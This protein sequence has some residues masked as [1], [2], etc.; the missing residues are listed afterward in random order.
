MPNVPI[1]T[2]PALAPT[3]GQESYVSN[4]LV[5]IIYGVPT[6]K[7]IASALRT[8]LNFVTPGPAN[9]TASRAG[10]VKTV[11]DRVLC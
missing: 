9:A 10:T 2:V 1:K 8:T 7:M 5:L 6:V 3:A 11:P 4:V